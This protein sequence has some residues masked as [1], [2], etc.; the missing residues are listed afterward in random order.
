MLLT[1]DIGNTNITL[2]AFDGKE[3]KFTARLAT[4]EHRT[5]DQYAIEVKNV[6]SLH[7][8][9]ASDFDGAIIGSVVPVITRFMSNAI[10]LLFG[11]T[12][13]ILGPGV[14]TG[15]NS[16]IDNPAQ[17]GADLVAG[18][19]AA[20]AYYPLPN[21]VCDL[22][23]ASTIF[24]L[25]AAGNMIGGVIYPGVRTSMDALVAKTALLQQVSFDAPNRVIGKNTIDCMQSGVVYGAAALLDGMMDRIEKEVGQPMTAIATGGYAQRII[26]NCVRKFKYADNLVLEGLRLIWEKNR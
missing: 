10:E 15:L 9:E 18:S 20:K 12:P 5:D 25:D 11:I 21:A 8:V 23:T 3:L 14:K 19:V 24:V 13:L 16:L 22:G 2:G 7:N 4:D 26:K 17:L 1:V 6:L